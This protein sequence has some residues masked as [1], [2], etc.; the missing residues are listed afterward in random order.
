[1]EWLRLLHPFDCKGTN[2]SDVNPVPFGSDP[3]G[4][5]PFDYDKVLA[6]R[7]ETLATGVPYISWV[8]EVDLTALDATVP[9]VAI[10]TVEPRKR[11]VKVNG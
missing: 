6:E 9:E 2:V 8:E 3:Y 7:G 11:Q 5:V 10:P 1:M 4:G